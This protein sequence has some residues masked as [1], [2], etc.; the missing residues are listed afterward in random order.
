[1]SEAKLSQVTEGQAAAVREQ[2]RH[3]LQSQSFAGSKRCQEFLDF[4]VEHAL[5]GDADALKERTI[6]AKLFGRPIDYETSSDPI[7]RVKANDVRRRLTRYNLEVGGGVPV[8]I[9]MPPGSYIPDFI[10]SADLSDAVAG[11]PPVVPPSFRPT[12]VRLSWLVVIGAHPGLRN[13][14]VFCAPAD[15]LFGTGRL[16]ETGI[17]E[18]WSGAGVFRKNRIYLAIGE[19]SG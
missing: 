2:L 12:R 1:M 10:W 16:L 19:A 15:S 18:R 17:A 3:I 13:R 11:T 7:V 6:G 9:T 5:R 4:V 8:R 14:R